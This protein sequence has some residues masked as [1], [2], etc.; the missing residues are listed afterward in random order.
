MNTIRQIT[1]YSLL[2][3]ALAAC[4]EEDVKFTTFEAPRWAVD[5]NGYVDAPHW[6]VDETGHDASPE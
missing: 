2:V 3:L 1:L 5:M 6:A 4:R